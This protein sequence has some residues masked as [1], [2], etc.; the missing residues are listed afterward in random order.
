M[1]IITVNSKSHPL[2][3]SVWRTYECSFPEFEKRT[4]RDQIKV[5]EDNRY[6]VYA[7][8]DEG[9]Y[10]GFIT[11]WEFNKY[12][13]IEHLA[14]DPINRGKSYGKAIINKL[15]SQHQDKIIIL[16]IDPPIDDISKR[17]LKFYEGL[18]FIISDLHHFN[19]PYRKG[20]E[21]H[22]LY[23]MTYPNPITQEEY[24]IF[25]NFLY[26]EIIQYCEQ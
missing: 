3:E 1:E 13:F 6:K 9:N 14:I 15:Q 24:E 23:I 7:I 2:F 17:R 21:G 22:R 19:L 5:L 20:G 25:N 12:C 11:L 8:S 18:G 26:T 16:E 4:K 10:V